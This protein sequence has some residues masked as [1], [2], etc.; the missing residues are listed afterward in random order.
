M[1]AVPPVSATPDDDDYYDDET[2]LTEYVINRDAIA[3]GQAGQAWGLH[4][5][6]ARKTAS[7]DGIRHIL[8]AL[9]GTATLRANELWLDT[10]A[11]IDI[12]DGMELRKPNR[13]LTVDDLRA[14]E[15]DRRKA[16]QR[17]W[18]TY[19]ALADMVDELTKTMTARHA[20][21][22]GD[23]YPAA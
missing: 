15:R 13:A 14:L 18:N 9:R 11:S 12:G 20:E 1:T 22:V 3:E 6:E 21:T 17:A 19:T 7:T 23:L 10:S 2:V 4:D 5:H 16:A 8:D